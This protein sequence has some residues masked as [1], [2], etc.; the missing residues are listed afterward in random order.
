MRSSIPTIQTVPTHLTLAGLEATLS[1]STLPEYSPRE[2]RGV[3][4]LL[5]LHL[6]PKPHTP[7]RSAQHV[8]SLPFPKTSPA[9]VKAQISPDPLLSSCTSVKL[10][11]NKILFHQNSISAEIHF[12]SAVST[13]HKHLQS[14]QLQ[15]SCYIN[16]EHGQENRVL[17]MESQHRSTV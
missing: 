3:Q 10:P 8:V 2:D 13:V 11:F 6:P 12:N 15:T 5:G 17:G 1:L 14:T 4:I 9:S 7:A 16:R